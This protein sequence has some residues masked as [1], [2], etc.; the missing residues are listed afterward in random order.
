[1]SANGLHQGQPVLQA[2]TSLEK[3][4]GVMIMLHGRGATAEDILTLASEFNQPEFAYLAPQAAG[5]QW[6]PNRF[7]MPVASNE[8]YLSSALMLV[9]DIVG[10]LVSA[11][12]PKTKMLLLGFSQGACLALEYAARSP[13]R[14]GGLAGLSG[15]LIGDVLPEY[16]GSMEETPVFLGCSDK[17]FHIPKERVIESAA[18]FRTLGANVTDR[19]YPNM[20][21]TVNEDE[22]AAVSRIMATIGTIDE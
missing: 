15:G 21:H 3:A 1:M 2:G 9:D 11:G 22:I 18:V 13:Q 5:Y 19:L 4:H 16:S 7:I 8:P 10:Q 20:G 12:I 6:Y 14:Y 17:D